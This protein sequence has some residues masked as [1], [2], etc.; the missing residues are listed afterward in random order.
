M[1]IEPTNR[2]GCFIK[3]NMD[4]KPYLRIKNIKEHLPEAYLLLA[5]DRLNFSKFKQEAETLVS[6]IAEERVT[7]LAVNDLLTALQKVIEEDKQEYNRLEGIE[8]TFAEN[9]Y[10]AC[11]KIHNV[12]KFIRMQTIPTTD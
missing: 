3:E 1:R 2:T 9:S 4:T 12:I 7:K 5:V 11:Q 8:K 10:K 6:I